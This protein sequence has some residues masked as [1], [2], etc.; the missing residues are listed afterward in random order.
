LELREILT[1]AREFSIYLAQY[2]FGVIEAIN[3]AISVIDA[4]A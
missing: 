3:E 4:L 1:V 2:G